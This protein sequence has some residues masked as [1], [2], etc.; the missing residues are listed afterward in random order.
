[1][2]NASMDI[3]VCFLVDMCKDSEQNCSSK[4]YWYTHSTWPVDK[5]FH[6]IIVPVYTLTCSKRFYCFMSSSFG[7]VRF[8]FFSSLVAVKWCIIIYMFPGGNEVENLLIFIGYSCYSCDMTIQYKKNWL[9]VFFYWHTRFYVLDTIPFHV[10]CYMNHKFI[11]PVY[12]LSSTLFTGS[13]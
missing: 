6:R 13:F 11:F 9:L 10:L 8:Y 4:E 1:M 2:N 7:F 3:L 12:A 5:L